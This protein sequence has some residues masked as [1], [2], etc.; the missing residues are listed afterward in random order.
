MTSGPPANGPSPWRTVAACT[1]R[2]ILAIAVLL[3]LYETLP[4]TAASP[5]VALAALIIGL[6]LFI[7]L[8]VSQFVAIDRSPHPGL[9]AGEALAVAI[10]LF[11]LLFAATYLRWSE[12]DPAAFSEHLD[13]STALYFTVTTFAT[14]GFGDITAVSD[15]ARDLVTAQIVAD[16]L[17]LGLVV[18]AMASVARRARARG[19]NG[20]DVTAP[21]PD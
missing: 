1:A 18:N 20:P 5:A 21:R 6:L 13:R 4:L 17:V 10:P 15:P 8:V 3:L 9:R 11:L 12:A 16:L 7:A 19:Q 14:V 2:S